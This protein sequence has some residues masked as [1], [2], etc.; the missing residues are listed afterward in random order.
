MSDNEENKKEIENIKKELLSL[1][2]KKEDLNIK[3]S[4]SELLLDKLNK[5]YLANKNKFDEAYQKA[6]NPINENLKKLDK[7]KRELDEKN[8]YISY[9]KRNL[10]KKKLMHQIN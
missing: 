6:M 8:L 2:G 1:N 7:T 3:I 5:E 4:Q 10:K 9:Q